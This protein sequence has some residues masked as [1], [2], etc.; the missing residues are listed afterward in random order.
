MILD[1]I[2]LPI[3]N[4]VPFTLISSGPFSGADFFFTIFTPGTI[5]KLASRLFALIPA[6]TLRTVTISPFS[7]SIKHFTKGI[8]VLFSS[9]CVSEAEFI[10][11]FHLLKTSFL[12]SKKDFLNLNLGITK[13]K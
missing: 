13:Y 10:M 5:P 11:H 1:A 8:G 3:T 4:E 12:N 9:S 7:H 2:P 6:F